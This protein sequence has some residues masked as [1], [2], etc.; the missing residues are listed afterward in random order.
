MAWSPGRRSN[1]GDPR[2]DH[3]GDYATF[4][5]NHIPDGTLLNLIFQSEHSL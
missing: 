1:A 2:F 3:P 4:N 5:S